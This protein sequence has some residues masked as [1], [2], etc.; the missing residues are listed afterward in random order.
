VTELDD[1]TEFYP[2]S[3]RKKR[4]Y[5]EPEPEK[6][7]LDELPELGKPQYYLVNNQPL[8]LYKIGAVARALNRK[9][10]TIRKWETEGFI[11]VS[12]YKMPGRDN[13]GQRRL[14][15]KEQIEQLRK[16]AYEEDILYPGPG[17][18]WRHIEKTNFKYKAAKAFNIQGE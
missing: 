11:P 8:A 17:G 14:Y 6:P 16:I 10:V 7:E 5:E 9:S 1:F 18:K 4:Q 3:S 15:S 2:G 13:R 12:S